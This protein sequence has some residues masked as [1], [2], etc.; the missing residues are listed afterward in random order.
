M[1]SR[2]LSHPVL[3]LVDRLRSAIRT[4]RRLHLE[5][6]HA[7]LL[8]TDEIYL[9]LSKLEALEMRRLCAE[10]TSDSGSATSGFGSGRSSSPGQSVGSSAIPLDVASRGA[11]L[12]LRE[13]AALTLRRRKPSTHSPPTM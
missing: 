12:L 8:M 5:P 13:E 10:Q 9:A 3:S 1:T 2:A 7:E 6:E 4:G 11:S